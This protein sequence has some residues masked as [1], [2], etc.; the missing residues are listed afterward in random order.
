MNV[1][2]SL[3]LFAYDRWANALV[4]ALAST[5]SD[6]QRSRPSAASYVSVQGTLVHILWSEW[7][8]LGRWTSLRST[9]DPRTVSGFDS[10]RSL[11]SA[12]ENEQR[13]FLSGL[14][15][16]DLRRSV[17]YQNPPG[18]TWTY[19]LR[20]MLQH[21]VNHSTYHRGQLTTMYRE[22]GVAP[23]PLDFL[24]YFDHLNSKGA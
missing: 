24:D 14:R 7:A 9:A 13:T 19:S 17:S 6:E 23:R 12:F 4:L 20:H 15:E 22:L 2:D 11:W 5:L 21:V 10:L 18:T 3:E 8:W 16:A 1:P